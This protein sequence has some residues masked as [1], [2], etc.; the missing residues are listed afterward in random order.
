M[1]NY[2]TDF[3]QNVGYNDEEQAVEVVAERNDPQTNTQNINTESQDF[4]D[5]WLL[6]VAKCITT[7]LGA[8]FSSL[9]LPLTIIALERRFTPNANSTFLIKLAKTMPAYGFLFGF[10][11]WLLWYRIGKRLNGKKDEKITE[12]HPD[13]EHAPMAVTA[14]MIANISAFCNGFILMMHLLNDSHPAA[15]CS[16]GV[17]IGTL[18]YF[19]DLLTDVGDGFRKYSETKKKQGIHIQPFF[20]QKIIQYFFTHH[21]EKFGWFLRE[22]FPVITGIIRSQTAVGIVDDLLH[23]K[24][25]S[26]SLQILKAVLGFLVYETCAYFARYEVIQLSQN[27][28]FAQLPNFNPDN[29]F[30]QSE[31]KPIRIIGKVANGELLIDTFQKSKLSPANSVYASFVFASLGFSFLIYTV[32]VAYLVT[33]DREAAANNQEGLLVNYFLSDD[34]ALSFSRTAIISAITIAIPIILGSGY[35]FSQTGTL[36]DYQEDKQS[37]SRPNQVAVDDMENERVVELR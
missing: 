14:A 1:E 36:R 27:L 18:N 22:V 21:I 33:T 31:I 11:T 29:A 2:V 25:S 15:A 7:P 13:A 23:E 32:F 16:F 30:S 10:R 5:S 4:D 35:T 12:I 37:I 26:L 19:V 28:T 9:S 17:C 34:V 20:R 6:F 8:A 24:M 3:D